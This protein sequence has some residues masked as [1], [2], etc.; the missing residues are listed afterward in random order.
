MRKN[1]KWVSVLVALM[2]LVLVG[3]GAKEKKDETAVSGKG[4]EEE[5]KVIEFW[6]ISLQPTFDDYFNTL[7]KEFEK[8]NPMIKVDWKDFPM[9]TLQNKLLTSIASDSAPDVV[10]VNADI[11]LSMGDKGGLS[12]VN[13]YLPK[14][15]QE[16][17]FE[18]IYQATELDGEVLAIPWYTSVPILYVNEE[19]TGEAGLTTNDLPKDFAG[20]SKW[21][22]DIKTKI[23]KYGTAVEI[24]IKDILVANGVE[25][26]NGDRSEV[27]FNTPQAVEVVKEYQKLAKANAIPKGNLDQETRAQLYSSKQTAS[28]ISGTTFIN[29][30]KSTAPDVYENTVAM[31]LPFDYNFSTTMF[32][33]VPSQSKNIDES[34]K[35]ADFVTNSTNQLEFSK[36]ANTLPSTKDSVED[37]FFTET[38]GSLEDETK[39]AAV[40]SLEKAKETPISQDVLE[41]INRELQSIIYS[42]KD[43]AE[44]LDQ[45]VEEVNKQLSE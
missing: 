20:Y 41:K 12:N 16:A 9:D 18:G 13:D 39:L 23:D 5:E 2:T 34:Y 3:C 28:V 43:V 14:E 29:K 1:V 33:T 31:S 21:A 15:S 7:I 10:N 45:L 44:A 27:I 24:N 30:F 32:L 17:F 26:F 6:T 19:L 37:P 36:V 40:K 22:S 35:F 8:E 11:A 38:D 4:A 25:V 42:D